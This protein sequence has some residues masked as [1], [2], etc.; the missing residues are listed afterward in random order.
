[1]NLIFAELIMAS[2]GVPVNFLASLQ[3][4]WKMGKLLCDIFGSLLTL[5]GK[6]RISIMYAK[7]SFGSG[8]KLFLANK[9]AN[10]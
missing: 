6:A 8:S 3:H 10:L 7:T 9:G 1:M 2:F 5:E 4:G